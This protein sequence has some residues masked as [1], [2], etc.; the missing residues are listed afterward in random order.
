MA[1]ET[2]IQSKK[3]KKLEEELQMNNCDIKTHFVFF[4][5]LNVFLIMED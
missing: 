3:K 2:E 1:L 4:T 5:C